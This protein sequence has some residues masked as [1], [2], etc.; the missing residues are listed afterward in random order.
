MCVG[1]IE[2][3]CG[4]CADD[5]QGGGDG[6]A[7]KLRIESVEGL[8]GPPAVVGEEQGWDA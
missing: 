3:M 6:S 7:K 5:G 1:R 4:L 8:S 2:D